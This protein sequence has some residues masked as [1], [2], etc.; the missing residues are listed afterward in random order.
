MLDRV[1]VDVPGEQSKRSQIGQ[2]HFYQLRFLW[3]PSPFLIKMNNVIFSTDILLLQM[4][5]FIPP[6]RSVILILL[7]QILVHSFS[8]RPF[9]RFEVLSSLC[10][11]D[12]R[13]PTGADHLNTLLLILAAPFIVDILLHI[14]NL[15]LLTGCIH[16]IGKTAFVTPLHKITAQSQNYPSW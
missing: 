4:I 11:L 7:L 15:T 1:L 8:F 9:N 13:K 5:S 3:A 14:L 6:V 12:P 2:P 10:S 16:N